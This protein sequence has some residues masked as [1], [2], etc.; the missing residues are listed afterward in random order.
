MLVNPG[1]PGGSGLTCRPRPASSPR[2][3]ARA[4]TGSA[5][6]RA[7]SA[8]HA[9]AVVRPG[10]LRRAPAGLRAAQV[11]RA[12]GGLADR[13]RLRAGL[14][15]R[16][17]G[18]ARHMRT[19]DVAR[20]VDAIRKALGEEDQLLRVLLRHLPGAGLHDPVPDPVRRRSS[21]AS[22]T[23]AVF[24][25][26]QPD[27][28][29]AFE[30]NIG[31]L[32]RLGREARQHVYHL[33][34]RPRRVP[35]LLRSATRCGHPGRRHHRPSGVVRRLPATP[36]TPS[37]CGRT[38]RR[39]GDWVR[40]PGPRRRSST[41]TRV[42]RGPGDDNLFAVYNAVQCTDA[43]WPGSPTH[44]Y[45]KDISRWHKQAPFLTW[46]NAWF[47]ASCHASGPSRPDT[48]VH[49]TGKGVGPVPADQP[50]AGRGHAVLRRLAV[51]KLL[52]E[53]AARQPSR[54]ARPTPVR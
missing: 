47:N 53:D 32:V 28:D 24:L 16:R 8:Q 52:H 33:G 1:G 54:V 2:A 11:G 31:H 10:L 3:P 12:R 14:R 37:S 6:T 23:R 38:R 18:A 26:G 4:T 41:P 7:A 45:R 42:R 25:P 22:S 44:K 48:P 13:P 9:A 15:R 30:R 36:G 46:G 17:P 21:T 27:Q 20:D 40:G 19:T 35:A 34:T 49:V 5:S 43:P 51:R 39:F 50:D 29:V